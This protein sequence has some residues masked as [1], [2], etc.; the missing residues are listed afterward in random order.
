MVVSIF[1]AFYFAYISRFDILFWFP[2]SLIT[3][4]ILTIIINRW[5]CPITPIAERYTIDR[6]ANFDIYLPEWLAKYN[7]RIF[8]VV[9]FVEILILLI[10]YVS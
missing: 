8:S 7:I 4:E 6:K 3:I 9:I 5:K 2:A 1:L 10:K